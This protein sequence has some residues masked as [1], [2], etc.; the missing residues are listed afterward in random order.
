MI[1][2]LSKD[3]KRSFKVSIANTNNMTI[4]NGVNQN[5][6]LSNRGKQATIVLVFL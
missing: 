3:F 6:S 5:R 4:C 2:A 1:V